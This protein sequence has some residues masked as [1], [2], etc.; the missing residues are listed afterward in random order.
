M[1][2]KSPR[3]TTCHAGRGVLRAI[4]AILLSLAPGLATAAIPPAE[5]AALDAL[6]QSTDGPRWNEHRFW[7]GLPGVEC[8]WTGVTCD[9]A[10]EHV[11]ELR[12]PD[13]NLRGALPDQLRDLTRLRVLDLSENVDLWGGIPAALG[14]LGELEVLD[15]HGSY[16]SGGIPPRLALL[17]RLRRLDLS[18][19]RLQGT[20]PPDLGYLPNLQLLSLAGN[21]LSG[22]VPGELGRLTNLLELHLEE[23]D[24]SGALPA[25]LAGAGSLE[26]IVLA[27]NRLGGPLPSWLGGLTALRLLDLSFNSMTGPLPE[28]LADLRNLV[29]LDLSG[30][31]LGGALPD[32]LGELDSLQILKL[33]DVMATG[34]IPRTLGNLNR[35]EALDLSTNRLEGS[36]PEEL[37]QLE[38][39]RSLILDQNRLTGV[40]PTWLG[41]LAQ[42]TE[43]GLESNRFEASPPE[44]LANLTRLRVLRL[45]ANRLVGEI[46][47][48]FGTFPS[49]SEV[50]LSWNGLWTGDED[51]GEWLEERNQATQSVASPWFDTQALPP[52]TV[53]VRSLLPTS[54]QLHWPA[55][56]AIIGTASGQ[57]LDLPIRFRV[58]IATAPDG[59]FE[60]AVTFAEV[61]PRPAND[62]RIVMLEPDTTYFL[63]VRGLAWPHK[64]NPGN[65]I[66]GAPSDVTTVHTP[67]AT[68]WYVEADGDDRF[69]CDAPQRACASLTG[70][71]DL[72]RDGDR[73]MVGEMPY[74]PTGASTPSAATIAKDISLEGRSPGSTVLTYLNIHPGVVVSVRNATILDLWTRSAE[75]TLRSVELRANAFYG[76]SV[77]IDRSLVSQPLSLRED[78]RAMIANT[79]ISY[80][81]TTRSNEVSGSMTLL[82]STLWTEPFAPASH[83]FTLDNGVVQYAGSVLAAGGATCGTKG[84]HASPWS[85]WIQSLGGNVVEGENCELLDGADDV[86]V[87]DA[88]LGPLEDN[89]GPVMTHMPHTDSPAVDHVDPTAAPPTDVRGVPRPQGAA[90]DAGACERLPVDGTEPAPHRPNPHRL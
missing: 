55:S 88:L 22:A 36:L 65:A 41:G 66:L 18:R 42:L 28:E 54:C 7:G 64:H 86:L 44:E 51:L 16:V 56:P 10:G 46:H 76:S 21:R 26:V 72:A 73:I 48:A 8:S 87:D 78:C 68:T 83:A 53:Q 59:P 85:P 20:I 13:N 24:L 11:V 70:A 19:C 43:L 29:S 40:L 61:G 77:L 33:A 84:W 5:R 79:T 6:Y 15:L 71:L 57:V 63:R 35:L 23:N 45:A 31:P 4:L 82:F 3:R 90:V 74:G 39:L 12:L 49:L 62:A 30:N 9:E 81:R 67:A 38:S 69:R 1:N 27:G 32:S 50:T 89:G 47:P 52:T 2:Q 60:P 80:P 75:V 14:G 34:A 25:T 37:S 17:A 58:E